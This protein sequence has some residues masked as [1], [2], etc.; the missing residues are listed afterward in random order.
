MG[1]NSVLS[2][3]V[4]GL[5]GS[6]LRDDKGGVFKPGLGKGASPPHTEAKATPRACVPSS[7]LPQAVWEQISRPQTDQG[8]LHK[9][10]RPGH[11]SDRQACSERTLSPGHCFSPSPVC[12]TGLTPHCASIS[13]TGRGGPRSPCPRGT[14]HCTD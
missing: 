14:V 1:S 4:S 2:G 11:S 7:P 3:G 12:V 8:S 13:Q 5:E 10:G 9:A 6:L